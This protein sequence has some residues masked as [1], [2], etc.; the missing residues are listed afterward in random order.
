VPLTARSEHEVKMV[1]RGASFAWQT[2]SGSASGSDWF[3]SSPAVTVL[4][5]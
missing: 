3:L 2:I 1:L 4:D 5:D